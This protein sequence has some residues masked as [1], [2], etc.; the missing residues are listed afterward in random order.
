MSNEIH[1]ITVLGAGA[2][3]TALARVASIRTHNV[4]LWGHDRAH[5]ETMR[6]TRENQKYLPGVSLPSLMNYEPD[7]ARAVENAELLICAIPTIYLRAVLAEQRGTVGAEVGVISV[8]KGI[9]QETLKRPTEI[10]AECLGSKRL[11][12]LSGPCHAEEVGRDCP[13][14]AVVAANDERLAQTTLAALILPMFRLYLGNDM[15]GMEIAGALKNVVALTA[16]ACLAL[17]LGDNAI[18]A[19][20]TRGLAEMTRLGVALGADPKTFAGLAGLGDLVATCFSKHSRNRQFGYDAVKNNSKNFALTSRHSVAEG[21]FSAKSAYDLAQRLGVEMPIV[22]QI[23]RVL[24][25]D[26]DPRRAVL[27]LMTRET[28]KE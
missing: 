19:M 6:Q 2:W 18:A 20:L 10:I 13:T 12:V 28:K 16:G 8:T 4:T 27:E 26:Y 7:F 15:L 24:F 14:T 25:A 22:Q 9:E 11:G 1:N 3:G 21:Y 5:L 23:N 17:D